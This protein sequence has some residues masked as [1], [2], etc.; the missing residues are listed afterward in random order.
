MRM[1]NEFGQ[2]PPSNFNILDNIHKTAVLL[3]NHAKHR[4]VG[5]HLP[6]GYACEFKNPRRDRFSIFEIKK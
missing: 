2:Q 1:N 6:K 5:A 4:F 3:D